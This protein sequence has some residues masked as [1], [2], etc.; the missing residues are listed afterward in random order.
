MVG[1][2]EE[3]VERAKTMAGEDEPPAAEAEDEAEPEASEEL[4][5]EPAAV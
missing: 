5:A 1:T 4:E 3:A 2:I